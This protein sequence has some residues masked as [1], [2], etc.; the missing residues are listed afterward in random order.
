MTRSSKFDSSAHIEALNTGNASSRTL[1]EALAVDQAVLAR[2]VLPEAGDQVHAAIAEAQ[3]MGILKRMM[4]IGAVLADRLDP[5]E[6]TRLAAHPSDTVRGWACFLIAARAET[7]PAGLL[8]Q[9][10]GLADDEH[11]AVREWAWMAARPRLA[12]DLEASIGLLADWTAD[13]SGRRRRFASEALRPRGVWSVHIP[14]L[15]QQ[16][17]MGEPILNPLRADPTRYVQDSVANWIN[18][19]AKTRPG[20]AIALCERWTTDNQGPATA[21]IVKRALRSVTPSR[22]ERPRQGQRHHQG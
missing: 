13:P 3:E 21:R 17:E 14:L 19:A 11:F 15:K 8:E 12:E 6:T 4:R 18:D 7:G 1:S 16:P 10:R 22:L 5:A 20:W 9:L 2:A